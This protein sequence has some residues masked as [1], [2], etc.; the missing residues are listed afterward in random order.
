MDLPSN[1]YYTIT[2]DFVVRF[3]K[4]KVLLDIL[5]TYSC[6]N[7]ADL[8]GLLNVSRGKLNEV[9]QGIAHLDRKETKKLVEL[10]CIC[11]G[12]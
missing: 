4:Q 10:F 11:C 3:N 6:A 5:Q 8:A 12:G 9:L 7:L 1:T 2:V